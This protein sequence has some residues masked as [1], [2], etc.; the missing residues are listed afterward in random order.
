MIAGIGTDIVAVAR[1]EAAFQRYGERFAARILTVAELAALGAN[2]VNARVLAKRF[3][4]KEAFAKAW[5]TGI[6][7]TLGWHD[8]A[9]GHDVHGKPDFIC[10]ARLLEDMRARGIT[11]AHLSISDER[12]VAIAF[13]VLEN[14]CP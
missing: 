6:G 5:G 2:G 13:V 8:I 9:I 14:T 3:A 12:E 10:S 7:A 11:H 4:A 1:I